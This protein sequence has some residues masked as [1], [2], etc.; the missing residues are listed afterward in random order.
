MEKINMVRIANQLSTLNL[1][2][3]MTAE[4]HAAFQKVIDALRDMANKI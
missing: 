3:K 2:W 4:Q 1:A